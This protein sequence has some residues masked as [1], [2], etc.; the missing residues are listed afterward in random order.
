VWPGN[1]DNDK[2]DLAAQAKLEEKHGIGLDCN[3]AHY[4]NNA[5]Q[6]Q[7]LGSYGYTQGN[8]TGSGLP[9]KFADADGSIINVYQQ[10]NNVYDQQYMEHKDQDGY[11]NAFK[12]IMDRS[13]DNG[14]YSYVS[15]RAHNN[16]YFF[17][18]VPLMK[19]LD[20]ANSKHIPVWTELQLLNFLKARDEAEFRNIRYQ[21]NQLTFTLHS[22]YVTEAKITTMVPSSFSN[23]KIQSIIVDGRNAKFSTHHVKGVNYAF[24]PVVAGVSHNIV[25]TYK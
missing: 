22:S 19:M 1:Y 14:V 3:Y 18:K 5:R 15:V 13:I 17:S 21:N 10:L 11:L 23:K 6:K 4:D 9:M 20:Y 25:V 8:Y 24:V 16:E 7:F 12:G 2:Y